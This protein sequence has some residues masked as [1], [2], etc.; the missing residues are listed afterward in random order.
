M[1]YLYFAKLF[2]N[3]QTNIN[4]FLY[5]CYYKGSFC[6]YYIGKLKLLNINN[7]NK[8]SANPIT[9]HLIFPT[10]NNSSIKLN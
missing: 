5:F 7:D 1:L 8:K 6:I 10:D 3:L 2:V 9:D 4:N